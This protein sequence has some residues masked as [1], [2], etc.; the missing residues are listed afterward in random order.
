MASP[1]LKYGFLRVKGG[2]NLKEILKNS[3]RVDIPFVDIAIIGS[4]AVDL[5]GNRIGKG[6]G[7]GD[8]EIKILKS[9]NKNLKVITNIHDL[10]LFEDFSYLMEEHD[11]KVDIIVTPEKIIYVENNPII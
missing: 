5:K 11:E 3:E 8:R 2:K 6:G 9:R 7:Y 1:R 10:Q 4:V